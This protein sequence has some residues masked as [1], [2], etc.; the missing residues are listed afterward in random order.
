MSIHISCVA[1][2]PSVVRVDESLRR[3]RIEQLQAEYDVQAVQDQEKRKQRQKEDQEAKMTEKIEEWNRLQ[4][5]SEGRRLSEQTSSSSASQEK[6][7]DVKSWRGQYNPL[8]G[9]S[10]S[11]GYRP[12]KKKPPGGGCCGSGGGCG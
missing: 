3:R 9:S 6:K 11:S 4:G 2:G 5:F 12:S 10:S 8:T 1:A 7:K